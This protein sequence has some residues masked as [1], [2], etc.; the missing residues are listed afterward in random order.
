MGALEV[1]GVVGVDCLLLGFEGYGVVLFEVFL[2]FTELILVLFS[3]SVVF[4][5]A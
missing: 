3:L 4:F 5:Y 1:R 2:D